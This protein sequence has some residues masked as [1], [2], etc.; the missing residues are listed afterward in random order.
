[1]GGDWN[2][3]PA[4]EVFCLPHFSVEI[5]IV[6]TGLNNSSG[7]SSNT[8]L[9]PGHTQPPA[10]CDRCA[11]T[12]PT[13]GMML[14]HRDQCDGERSVD[15]SHRIKT[16]PSVTEPTVSITQRQ[17]SE[18]KDPAKPFV[19]P[20]CQKAFAKRQYLYSHRPVHT[21]EKSYTCGQCNKKFFRY[22]NLKEHERIHLAASYPCPY[23]N[24]KFKQSNNRKSHMTTHTKAG[25]YDCLYCQE[26]FMRFAQLSEHLQ[27][28]HAGQI[29]KA[30]VQSLKE[31]KKKGTTC[32][33]CQKVFTSIKAHKLTHSGERPY[34]CPRCRRTFRSLG[35]LTSHMSIHTGVKAYT[36]YWCHKKFSQARSLREH[37]YT[38]N[39]D[40]PFVC[41]NCKEQ[42]ATARELVVH[43]MRHRQRI[44]S[45]PHCEKKST[46]SAEIEIHISTH[47]G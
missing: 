29:N 46:S 26:K 18:K 28:S 6:Q 31:R 11:V 5:A 3:H 14:D 12:F 44:F 41:D 13:L 4:P 30:S 9:L 10:T 38:H 36:C 40:K 19:C 8:P 25:S 7:I 22:S 39:I 43:R 17:T 27:K 1:M 45:C 24:K 37:L 21:K 23:C 20:I 15:K 42:F 35:H 33:V 2:N 32:E 34:P 16:M 47:T